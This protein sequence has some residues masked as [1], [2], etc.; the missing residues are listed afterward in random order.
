M[1]KS[2]SHSTTQPIKPVNVSN[3]TVLRN[4]LLRHSQ[5]SRLRWR[6]LNPLFMRQSI[7]I[8]FP[9]NCIQHVHLCLYFNYSIFSLQ[10]KYCCLDLELH[11]RFLL[12][13]PPFFSTSPLPLFFP[14]FYPAHP[15][16]GIS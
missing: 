10:P 4:A 13:P 5:H 11:M 6:K 8:I 3:R 1:S 9:Q 16:S 14:S 15:P 12:P 7:K 2:R